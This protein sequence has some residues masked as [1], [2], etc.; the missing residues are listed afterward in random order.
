MSDSV[1]I[2]YRGFVLNGHSYRD[3]NNLNW[4]YR[5]HAVTDDS[6]KNIHYFNERLSYT[7]EYVLFNLNTKNPFPQ[8]E[9]RTLARAKARIDLNLFEDEKS[10]EEV[11]LTTTPEPEPKSDHAIQR[12]I[13]GALELRRRMSPQ[14]YK[15]EQIEVDGFCDLLGIPKNQYLFNADI[16]KERDYVA[17]GNVDQLTIENG[18]MYI[19]VDGLDYLGVAR[20]VASPD[21]ETKGEDDTERA[22]EYD[23]VVSYASEDIKLA[24]EIATA[25][26]ANGFNVFYDQFQDIKVRL[27]GT[28]LYDFFADIYSKHG[29]YCLVLISEPYAKKAWTNHERQNAQARALKNGGEYIL[30]VRLDDTELPGMPDTVGYIDLRSTS[31]KELVDIIYQ[32]LNK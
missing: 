15:L 14:R 5:V 22:H 8:L 16:L 19:T 28:N 17:E 4:C 23:L 1:E 3:S 7:E 6:P 18:G 30:P 11:I 20:K 29:R 32:K 2:E 21:F 25:V 9:A 13:L 10:Y 24:E 12:Y 31:V 27:W 26:Q